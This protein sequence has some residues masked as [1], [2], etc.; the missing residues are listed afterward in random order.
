MTVFVII[1]L[2][3]PTIC[4][5]SFSLFNCAKLDDGNSYLKRDMSVQCWTGNHSKMAVPIALTF[6]LF[7]VFGFPVFIFY[8]LYRQREKINSEDFIL[9]YGLF[10]VGLNDDSFFWEVIVTN[11]RKIIF[12]ICST[13]LSTSKPVFKAILGILAMFVQMQLLYAY[14]PYIDPR[15]NDIEHVG[16]YAS[17]S[18]L[19]FPFGSRFSLHV[20][21]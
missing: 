19:L 5:L 10:F 15:F 14:Q 20:C 2:M 18:L 16:I 9:R 17:V 11:C 6:I 4:N 7:W 12:I 21:V 8:Q 3:Y 1:Y 13:L